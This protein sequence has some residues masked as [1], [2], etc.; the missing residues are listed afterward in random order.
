LRRLTK[1]LLQV[2][3]WAAVALA[4]VVLVRVLDA[5]K[6]PDLKPWHRIVPQKE[7]AAVE[8]ND[9]F[10]FSD[11]LA[12]EGEVFREVSE[13]IESVVTPE[14]RTLVNRYFSG[15]PMNPGHFRVNWNRTQELVPETI[16]GGALLLHGLT[17]SPYSMR[18]LAE[19]LASRG[20]YALCLRMPGHG[21]VPAGLTNLRWED[22]VAAARVGARR[23][24]EK[25]GQSRPF[26]IFGYSNGAA[27]ALDYALET[28]EAPALPRP[29]RLVLLSP[30]IGVAP[31]PRLT[32]LLST[33]ALVPYFEKSRWLDVLP[34][35]NPFKYNSFPVNA[36]QQ[37]LAI[38]NALQKALASAAREGRISRL[39]PVLAFQSVVDATVQTDAV[40]DDFFAKLPDNGSELVL[41]DLNRSANAKS[42]LKAP[43]EALIGRLSSDRARR[44]RFTL[45]TNAGPDTPEVLAR[46]F[47]KEGGPATDEALGLAWPPQFFSLSH[48]AIPFA[49]DDPVFGWQPDLSID[50]GVRLGILAPRGE[51]D[52]LLT[53]LDSLLRLNANPFFS[54]MERRILETVAPAR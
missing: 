11:Y 18:R 25:I 33:F 30:E 13:R 6:L 48:V 39:P 47:P 52:V 3:S 51:K 42:F 50:Y 44:Y 40:A 4:T 38:T 22:W 19:I 14:D 15:S 54:Y 12:R 9:R 41:F 20:I 23:V 8:M 36:G 27:I 45:V 26:V 21:T 28:L 37:S 1:V 35:Y 29:D 16:Q 32:E 7:L 2:V 10:T 46:T 53:P 49:P 43:N 34:E 17:D 5:R 31:F 24:R